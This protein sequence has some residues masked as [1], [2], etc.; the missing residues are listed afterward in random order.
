MVQH[1]I[2]GKLKYAIKAVPNLQ[3]MCFSMEE[4]GKTYTLVKSPADL[5][6]NLYQMITKKD[7]NHI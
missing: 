5:Q 1:D 6:N 3:E 4:L 2:L 7:L